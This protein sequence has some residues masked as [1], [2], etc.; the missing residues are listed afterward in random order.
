M[1]VL[2]VRMLRPSGTVAI[3]GSRGETV[4]N[5]RNVM[6]G[7]KSIIGVLGGTKAEVN[8]CMQGVTAGLHSGAL[9]PVV[10]HTYPLIEADKAHV[11]VIEHAAGTVGKIV[12][13][14]SL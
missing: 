12:L 7:E 1:L 5:P 8:E 13:Q 9:N 3:I 10:G 4:M 11:E 6:M 14:C 2:A